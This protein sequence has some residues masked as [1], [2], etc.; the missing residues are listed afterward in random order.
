MRRAKTQIKYVF[1]P[2]HYSFPISKRPT[3]AL[4]SSSRISSV[5]LHK[6]W[7][8]APLPCFPARRWE[9]QR[10]Q[11]SCRKERKGNHGNPSYLHPPCVS[12]SPPCTISPPPKPHTG[13][14]REQLAGWGLRPRVCRLVML[15]GS[16]HWTEITG[17]DLGDCRRAVCNRQSSP[18]L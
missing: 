3:L 9:G 16:P 2:H 12:F 1:L 18:L 5:C 11:S 8:S 15:W 14:T 4:C 10:G 7:M 13:R 17:E 6:V